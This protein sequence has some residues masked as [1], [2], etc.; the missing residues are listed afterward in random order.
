[1]SSEPY[2][3][4]SLN[5]DPAT[6]FVVSS[7]SVAARSG[8]RP[9]ERSL[10]ELAERRTPVGEILHG[11]GLS[12]AVTMQLLRSLCERR[13]LQP[14]LPHEIAD[15]GEN[16]SRPN[17]ASATQDLTA[18]IERQAERPNVRAARLGEDPFADRREGSTGAREKA[19]LMG[20]EPVAPRPRLT[21]P[22]FEQATSLVAPVAVGRG[23]SDGSGKSGEFM[24]IVPTPRADLDRPTRVGAYEVVT[25]MAQGGLGS[26]YLCRRMGAR[27]FQHL[28]ALKVI[29]QHSAEAETAARSFLREG[30]VG[31]LLQHPNVLPIVDLGHYRDQPFL[32]MDYVEGTSLATLLVDGIRCPA[33]LIVPVIIDV[34][35][36]L[37]RA[38]DLKNED[39]RPL[40]L[41]HCDVSPDNILVGTDGAG[42]LTD[43]GSAR[44]SAL[45]DEPDRDQAGMGKPAFMAPEQLK[46]EMVDLRTDIFAVGVV[47]WTALTGRSLFA[48]ASYEEVVMNI[49]RRPV[50]PPSTYGGPRSLDD[51]CMKALSRN[52]AGRFQSA[53]EMALALIQVGAAENFLPGGRAIGSWVVQAMSDVLLERRQRLQDV[54]SG[55]TSAVIVAAEGAEDAAAGAPVGD[56]DEGASP[57]IVSAS[58]G[59]RETM[60]LDTVRS[61]RKPRPSAASE[62]ELPA[63]AGTAAGL[64]RWL[65]R[66]FARSTDLQSED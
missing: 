64:W 14:Q 9:D 49:M 43:F 63:V 12:G 6:V 5:L 25:R 36:G 31:M 42:R 33:A 27:S 62:S 56:P 21:R 41:V 47:L 7:P 30:R 35:R 40:G 37:Q 45:L 29:R 60:V 50:L 18:F 54:A 17:R 28:Y 66:R 34:L 22:A 16:R 26:V 55:A 32:V 39:G 44:F 52:R 8:L 19:T 53:D 57:R 20:L 15:R 24:A 11:S 38:H 10:L 59:A 3:D 1:M 46:G 65:A 23:S 4:S 13:F 2:N 51:I 48:N 61:S 58:P